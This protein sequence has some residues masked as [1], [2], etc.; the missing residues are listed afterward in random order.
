MQ[1]A[2]AVRLERALDDAARG[3]T[4]AVRR[5]LA[6]DP[7]LVQGRGLHGQSL[8]WVAVYKHRPDLVRRLLD[9]GA[10]PNAPACD[11]PRGEIASD[12]VRL[13]TIVSVTP[14]AL[15]LKQR[16]QL[17]RL[18]VEHGAVPDV[19]TAAWLGDRAGV[20]AHLERHPELVNATDPAEDVQEVTP[21]V[22]ALA[23]GDASVVAL[24]LGRGA[25]VR[26]HSGKLLRVA[27]LLNR[28]DLVQRLLAHG[29][30]ARRVDT[31]GPLDGPAR[32]I[33]A[34]LLAHGAAVPGALLPRACRADVSRNALHRVTV[35]LGYGADVN[36][37]SRE[38]L[39]ALHYAVRGGAL[40]VIRRLL[41]HGAD[42]AARDPAGLP[43]LLHLAK[44]RAARR[45]RGRARA[46]R[47]VR[48]RSRRAHRGR[49]DPALLLRP[50]GGCAG[51]AL[52]A[53]ARRRSARRE[54]PR[55]AR[56]GARRA[57]P[58]RG[59]AARRVTG[60]AAPPARAGSGR[61]PPRRWRGRGASRFTVGGQSSTR[62]GA[63]AGGPS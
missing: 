21:L 31:L 53:R 47:G 41:D 19:F 13:G 8:L 43:P 60:R 51:R 10:D 4:E 40:P 45:P 9:A 3:R 11:P 18:L 12:R 38:G 48:R 59:A 58:R 42:A 37:R 17:A 57:A 56:R 25:A 44:T 24:L 15:A 32:P 6:A 63:G 22:H 5:A 20:A 46:A 26:A 30:D 28:P 54:R 52:A 35:L 34:L 62:P 29:A 49:G 14:L 55:R 39:T 50:P 7:L 27:I 23:G 33:A 1:D 61:C 2:R 16:P 36:S